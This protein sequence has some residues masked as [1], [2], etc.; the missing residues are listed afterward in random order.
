[1]K[2]KTSLA[3]LVSAGLLL[4]PSLAY[5][6]GNSPMWG[7]DTPFVVIKA[8]GTRAQESAF[9]GDCSGVKVGKHSIL[10]A[11][12]CVPIL[13]MNPK[14]K[15]QIHGFVFETNQISPQKVEMSY[16]MEDNSNTFADVDIYPYADLALITTREA[17][18]G[19]TISIEAKN[20]EAQTINKVTAC[21]KRLVAPDG[22]AV[23]DAP[24]MS[25][26]TVGSAVKDPSRNVWRI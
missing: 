18:K 19:K 6:A 16:P 24:N 26:I 5:G 8:I 14:T 4:S 15:T 3:M 2:L 21:G 12:H 11:A 22:S 9:Y 10:T 13:A 17:M 1:M 7:Q 20:T 25:C 23:T